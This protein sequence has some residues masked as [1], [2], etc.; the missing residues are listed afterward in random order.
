MAARIPVKS[1]LAQH[2]HAAAS[3]ATP[4]SFARRNSRIVYGLL[5]FLLT[6]QISFRCLNRRMP[7]QKLSLMFTTRWRFDFKVQ[8]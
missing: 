4:Y 2:Q 1:Q 5:N 7:Q 3:E 8:S 6:A